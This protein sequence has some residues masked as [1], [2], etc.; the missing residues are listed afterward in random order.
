M[1][2]TTTK[3]TQEIQSQEK[4]IAFNIRWKS[5]FFSKIKLERRKESVV[6]VNGG[7]VIAI[8]SVATLTLGLRPKQGGCKLAGQEGHSKVTSHA[9]G[10]A[11]SVR[12]WTLTFLRELLCWELESQKD[13]RIF[14]AP[15]QGSK[16]IA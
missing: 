13:S 1:T 11:K 9:S 6:Y 12:A 4:F 10:N 14:R 8:V 15:L 5:T 16:P 2:T 3:E 7:R